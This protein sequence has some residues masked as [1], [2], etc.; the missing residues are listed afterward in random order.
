M[1]PRPSEVDFR[2]VKKAAPAGWFVVLPGVL[3]SLLI[4]CAA[5]PQPQNLDWSIYGND[6]ANTRYS[7]L[8]QV[9]TE[10]VAGLRVAWTFDMNNLEAQECTPIAVDGPLYVTTA[11]GR[12]AVCSM[13]LWAVR[14]AMDPAQ[15]PSKTRWISGFCIDVMETW[16]RECFKRRSCL[17]D[18]GR[19]CPSGERRWPTRQHG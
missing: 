11:K 4:G 2:P 6:Y 7:H 17:A 3:I 8:D 1:D 5:P 19:K 18:P 12:A 9:N 15:R 10:N 16:P 14:T 13:Q